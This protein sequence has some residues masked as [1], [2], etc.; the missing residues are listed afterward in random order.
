MTGNSMIHHDQRNSYVGKSNIFCYMDLLKYAML[1]V[2]KSLE[3][4]EYKII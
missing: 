2:W 3:N 1:F 4:L